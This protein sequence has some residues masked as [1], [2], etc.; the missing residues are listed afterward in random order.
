MCTFAYTD[1]NSHSLTHHQK[2]QSSVPN[3]SGTTESAIT[4]ILAGLGDGDDD[5]FSRLIEA[6]YE[7]L[8]D[9]AEGRLRRQFGTQF[10]R[11]TMVPE[12]LAHETIEKLM[13]QRTIATNSGQFFAIATRLMMQVMMDYQRHRLAEKR[14]AGNRGAELNHDAA[15]ARSEQ[16]PAFEAE[17]LRIALN[18]LEGLD[19]RKSEVV[20]LHIAAGMSLPRVADVLGVSLPT[21]ER[22]WRFARAWLGE[23]LQSEHGH[24]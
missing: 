11:I 22:D 24:V 2:D 9:V 16:T 14:G 13:Q 17:P 20:T 1:A 10:A 6:V 5:A 21:V 18:E 3:S 7:D 12:S 23:R 15:T 4:R 8:C 19:P